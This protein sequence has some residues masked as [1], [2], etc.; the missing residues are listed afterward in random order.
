M[1]E[2]PLPVEWLT[3]AQRRLAGVAVSCASALFLAA[4]VFG[5][6]YLLQRFV[7]NFSG[8]IWPL[9]VASIM[10]LLLRPVVGFF[11]NWCKF[12]RI[13]SIALLYV[14]VVGV[15][16]VLGAV[17]LPVL[18]GQ[19]LG[20]VRELPTIAHNIYHYAK[21]VASRHPRVYAGL[22]GFFDKAN[23]DEYSA[24]ATDVLQTLM[25]NAPS[26]L[27]SAFATV[28][29]IFATAASIAI[30]PIY[31]FFLLESDHDFVSDLRQQLTFLKPG[32][33]H[34]IV[35]LVEQFVGILVSFFRG[36]L[37]IGLCLG[38][39]KAIGF[40]IIGVQ[41]GLVLGLIFGLLNVV[42]YLGTILGLATILPIAYFQVGGGLALVI[43][44]IAVF[45]IV[46]TCEGYFLTPRIMGKTTGL[47]PMVIII[48]IFFWG[49]ALNGLLGMVLAVPLTAFLVVTWR[50]LRSKYLPRHGTGFTRPPMRSNSPFPPL[51]APPS[52]PVP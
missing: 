51:S 28:K 27:K 45:A 20:L 5:A 8:V 36:Q 50:L 7:A 4:V 16:V 38:V 39:L 14:L 42:P 41:F 17:L 3:P 23:L 40:T 31:L 24:K 47:H 29:T 26:T 46:Q 52:G 37:L 49:E 21:D 22:H 25:S 32:L 2:P 19:L 6:L 34:D 13:K 11:E 18:L 30:V 15:C 35:F 1:S 44:A 48:S 33:R 43:K 12:G 10:S 9:A